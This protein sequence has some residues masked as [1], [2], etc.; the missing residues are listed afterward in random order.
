MSQR[1]TKARSG[2]AGGKALQNTAFRFV[3][4]FKMRLKMHGG[5]LNSAPAAAH[6][7]VPGSVPFGAIIRRHP[8]AGD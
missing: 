8:F 6:R 4:N 2:P 1:C 7:P 3:A 5:G